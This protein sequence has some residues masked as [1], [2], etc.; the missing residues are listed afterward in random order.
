MHNEKK[1]GFALGGLAGNNA[2]G[3]GFLQAALDCEIKPDF[4]SCT[5]GQI[6]WTLKYLQALEGGDSLET[7]LMEEIEKASPY[8]FKDLNWM[9][10]ITSGLKG[11]YEP[12]STME[13]MTEMSVNMMNSF[14]SITQTVASQKNMKNISWFETMQSWKP[15]RT[16]RP[17]R[18]D[19]IFEDISAAFNRADIGIALNGY[20]P[21][22]GEE[23]VYLNEKARDTLGLQYGQEGG[24]RQRTFYYEISAENLKKALWLYQYGF[25]EGITTID[26]AYYRQI[27]LSELVGADKVFVARP[28][29]HQWLGDL[30]INDVSAKD[31]Q[32][33][34]LFNGSYIGERDKIALINKLI[35]QGDLSKEKFN[36]VDLFELEIQTQEGFFDYVFEKPS[37]FNNAKEMATKLF[38]N[39][40]TWS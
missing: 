22:K 7:I 20:A 15:S 28:I 24:Y 12:I 18:T 4:I 9:N 33:E 13:T 14:K 16:L 5:S 3:A 1:I 17:A 37:V 11:V 25:P 29:N 36:Q 34:L 8:P 21:L 19:Q 26:G 32:T 31:L 6:F 27:M 2:F 30:P 40:A 38:K 10:L 35:E 23:Y 39:P